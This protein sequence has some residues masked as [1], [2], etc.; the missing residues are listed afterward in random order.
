MTIAKKDFKNIYESGIKEL[1]DIETRAIQDSKESKD[2]HSKK[3]KNA[4]QESLNDLDKK[5]GLLQVE[6]KQS[7]NE[8]L[9][10]LQDTL[11]VENAQSEAFL[12]SLM[13]ELKILTG[14]MKVKLHALKQAHH[15]NVNFARTVASEHYLTN[16]EQMSFA[17][18]QALANSLQNLGAKA[19]ANFEGLDSHLNKTLSDIES[20]IN[21]V[22]NSNL[23]SLKGEADTISDHSSTLLKTLFIDSQNKLNQLDNS[24]RKSSTEVDSQA[25]ALLEKI[26]D[27]AESVEVEMNVTYESVST[28]HFKNADNRLS[29]FADELSALHDSTTEQLITATDK[30]A[31]DLLDRSKQ[32]QEGLRNRCDDV[33][34]RVDNLFGSFQENL[35]DR[36]QFSRGQKRALESDKNRILVAVQN[37]L[38]SIQK[39]FAQ[40]IA[41]MLDQS[42]SELI[43]M[44]QGIEKQMVT[45][46]ESL[47]EKM[48][49]G[50]KIIQEEIEAEVSKF[51]QELS[52]VRTAALNEISEAAHGNLSV[53]VPTNYS[54]SS[55]DND[56]ADDIDEFNDVTSTPSQL[57]RDVLSSANTLAI[58]NAGDDDDLISSEEEMTFANSPENEFLSSDTT[59]SSDDFLAS[60]N[61]LNQSNIKSNSTDTSSEA[62]PSENKTKRSRRRKENRE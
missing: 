25:A 37:E 51:L 17:L 18:E 44:T 40:K 10:K 48:G 15:E 14:Q 39:A 49:D 43:E 41:G 53:A 4:A 42:K 11:A 23:D 9:K 45:A 5:S 46:T 29:H 52:S 26:S 62:G 12:S 58:V 3:Q 54:N 30:L 22:S 57:E 32:V 55:N 60:E 31:D 2:I 34:N 20:G 33:V 24:A 13:A 19:K 36:L 56:E 61:L 35:N 47:G 38:L 7:I 50:A 59:E 8:S 21:S 1:S 28:G 27:H 6:L 16:T